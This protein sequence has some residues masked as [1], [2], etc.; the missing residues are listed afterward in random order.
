MDDL[1]CWFTSGAA[2]EFAYRWQ[3]LIAAMLALGAAIW[4]IGVIKQQVKQQQKALDLQHDE[5]ND[6]RLRKE[7]RAQAGLPDALVEIMDYS[8]DCL[9]E[10][11]SDEETVLPA[12]PQAAMSVLK[13]AI[14]FA[15]KDQLPLFRD[16]INFFQVQNSRMSDYPARDDEQYSLQVQID[17]V[18]LFS[19]AGNLLDY[20]RGGDAALP[21]TKF[22]NDDMRSG[23]RQMVG[24]RQFVGNQA[25]Y[26]D[27]LGHI[28][29]RHRNNSDAGDP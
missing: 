19:M 13:E 26:N 11:R 20:G 16:I 21:N 24:L 14:E 18:Y 10:L 4:T 5:L 29:L 17:C 22:S 3:T 12:R 9:A 23:L 7:V 27:L 2:S 1:L 8:R 28:D 25:Q 6:L 15:A